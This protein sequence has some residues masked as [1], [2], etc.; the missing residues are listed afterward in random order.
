[1]RKLLIYSTICVIAS[2]A[3][4]LRSA[5][6][7]SAPTARTLVSIDRPVVK[8]K[9]LFRHAGAREDAILGPAP[10]PG[11]RIKVGKRQLG[12]IAQRYQVP[13]LGDDG[14]A[15]VVIERPGVP[16]ERDQIAQALRSALLRAGASEH[17]AIDLADVQLPMIPPDSKP[18]ILVNR[19][20]FDRNNNRFRSEISITAPNMNAVTMVFSGI[21]SPA[22]RGVIAVHRLEP[23]EIL[24]VADLRLS[25][26]PRG[27]LPRGAVRDVSE[28]VGME[29]KRMIAEGSPLGH[30][31]IA[32]PTLITRGATVS[33]AVDMP[34]LEV[35]AHGIALA[36]GGAGDVIPVINPT[37]H[38]IVQAVID[39]RNQAHVLAGSVPMP[40][41][42]NS[43]YYGAIG[44]QP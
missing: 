19:L 38:E 39:G 23:G 29:V 41:R 13:W 25:W 32:S 33:L 16:I 4:A 42:G 2:G 15:A 17:S 18:K 28:A 11:G 8:L 40:S 5:R 44:R 36:A 35:T 34:G 26:V 24:S 22:T 6:A 10:P 31:A 3:A 14:N 1:M 9:D 43:P 21:A 27:A 20:A 12:V 30:Q 7:Q 37:S